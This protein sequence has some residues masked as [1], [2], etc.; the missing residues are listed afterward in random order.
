MSRKPSL[1][2]SAIKTAEQSQT[3]AP[4]TEDHSDTQAEPKRRTRS[5][6]SAGSY[7][8]PSRANKSAKTH[9]LPPAYWETLEELSF[10][11]RDQQGKRIP[12]ERLV[13]E[14]L[15]LLFVKHNFPVVRES[16]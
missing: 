12:Q 11:T 5:A 4:A 8:A 1:L 6:Q 14:A 2:A 7:V 13:A 10:R 15:N 9:Y 16:D 3:D